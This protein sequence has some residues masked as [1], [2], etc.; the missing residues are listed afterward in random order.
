MQNSERKPKG[1]AK[2][3]TT[4]YPEAQNQSNIW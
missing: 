3:A 1:F 4:W 2:Y